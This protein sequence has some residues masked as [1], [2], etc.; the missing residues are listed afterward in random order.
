MKK[1]T[2]LIALPL[3]LAGCSDPFVG[4]Y[5]FDNSGEVLT[6]KSDGTCVDDAYGMKT[7]CSWKKRKMVTMRFQW[8]QHWEI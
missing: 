2:F 3:L 8:R 6:V 4:T 1:I 7:A 5:E